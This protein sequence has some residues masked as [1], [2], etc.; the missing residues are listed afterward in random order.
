M[1]TELTLSE[2]P[3]CHEFIAFNL[4]DYLI[5]IKLLFAQMFRNMVNEFALHIR[6]LTI[7]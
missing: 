6:Q 5:Q 2:H 3:H 4:A 1:I 7:R